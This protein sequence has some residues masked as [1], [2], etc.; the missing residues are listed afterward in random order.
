MEKQ[1]KLVAHN[2]LFKGETESEG[3]RCGAR[4]EEEGVGEAGREGGGEARVFDKG[5]DKRRWNETREEEG[6]E[7]RKGKEVG[8]ERYSE[9]EVMPPL[10]QGNQPG[11]LERSFDRT[12]FT[13]VPSHSKNQ[14]EPE[15]YSSKAQ[16]SRHQFKAN[17]KTSWG[18]LLPRTPS[19]HKRAQKRAQRERERL[20]LR[21]RLAVRARDDGDAGSLNWL[22]VSSPLILRPVLVL[23]CKL[24]F[25][26]DWPSPDPLVNRLF[27]RQLQ[28]DVVQ[29][30][31]QVRAGVSKPV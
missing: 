16:S 4:G 19:S 6:V 17:K 9:M 23:R 28:D 10:G 15:E 14:L 20:A 1:S 22:G 29:G 3:E 12:S 21:R 5:Q 8:D 30:R 2:G 27:Y 24:Y 25:R 26:E 31:V 11:G 13:P 7:E 18:S